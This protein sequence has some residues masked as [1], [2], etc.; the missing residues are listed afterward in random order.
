MTNWRTQR[1]PNAA[2]SA[3]SVS[4]ARDMASIDELNLLPAKELHDRAVDRATKHLDVKFFYELLEAIP[5][6]EA[7]TGD[8]ERAS[9]DVMS[10]RVLVNDALHA[11]EGELAE[12]LKPFYV[13]YLA[14]HS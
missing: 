10:M 8:P 12:A 13:E 5:A 1:Y 2:A 11:D 4:F 6:A 3:G 14:E 9:D 7:A